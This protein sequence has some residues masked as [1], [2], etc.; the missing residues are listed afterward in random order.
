MECINV[1]PIRLTTDSV[2]ICHEILSYW[3][4]DVYILYRRFLFFESSCLKRAKSM[5]D[6]VE[7][8]DIKTTLRIY[9]KMELFE[10]VYT[11]GYNVQKYWINSSLAWGPI[12]DRKNHQQCSQC[13]ILYCPMVDCITMEAAIDEVKTS[14][15]SNAITSGKGKDENE[16]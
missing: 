5:L 16:M 11:F 8:V 7:F 9:W 1:N 4:N 3:T 15:K 6:A 2:E 12:R 14:G 13:H 10:L